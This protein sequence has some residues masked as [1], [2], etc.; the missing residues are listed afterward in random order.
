MNPLTI[1]KNLQTTQAEN[2]GPHSPKASEVQLE[3][4]HKEHQD[5]PKLR[6]VENL[7]PV[8]SGQS[9]NGRTDD[10][11]NQEVTQNRSDTE[12]ASERGRDRCRDEIGEGVEK[13]S[14][15]HLS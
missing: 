15:I 7:F 6:K 4:D 13:K 14:G 10:N 2:R 8:L 1:P 5:D 9:K 3:P 12:A 11:S